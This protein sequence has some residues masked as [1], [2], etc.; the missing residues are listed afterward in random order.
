[1]GGAECQVWTAAF[2]A[3]LYALTACFCS[4]GCSSNSKTVLQ[5]ETHCYL[6][7]KVGKKSPKWLWSIKGWIIE[8]SLCSQAD[9]VETLLSKTLSPSVWI[10]SALIVS[11]QVMLRWL[12]VANCR[13]AGFFFWWKCTTKSKNINKKSERPPANKCNLFLNAWWASQPKTR[14]IHSQ[15]HLREQLEC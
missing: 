7:F 14:R 1:M 10:P 8:A 3:S 4:A 11:H 9:R 5:S 12:M 2:P 13:R 6:N 15:S